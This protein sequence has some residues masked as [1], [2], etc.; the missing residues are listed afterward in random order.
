MRCG[1]NDNNAPRCAHSHPRAASVQ[2]VSVKRPTN[3]EKVAFLDRRAAAPRSGHLSAGSE[4]T[5]GMSYCFYSGR[6]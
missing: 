2:A 5:G 4:E 1:K 3:L 6:S